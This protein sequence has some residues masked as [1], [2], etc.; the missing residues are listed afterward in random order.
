MSLQNEFT[1]EHSSNDAHL[2]YYIAVSNLS[3][4]YIYTECV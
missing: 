4:N 3:V 1:N 2:V